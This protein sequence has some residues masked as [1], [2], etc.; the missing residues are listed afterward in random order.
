MGRLNP[1]QQARPGTLQVSA[2]QNRAKSQMPPQKTKVGV[3]DYKAEMRDQAY[4]DC[5]REV[6]EVIHTK[7]QRLQALGSVASV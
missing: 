6:G 7:A 1:L 3:I 4:E 5:E 2:S